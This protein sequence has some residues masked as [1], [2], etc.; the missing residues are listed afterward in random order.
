MSRALVAAILAAWAAAYVIG[1]WRLARRADRPPPT[2][3]AAAAMTA[4]AAVATA[5]LSPLDAL[6]HERFSAHMVQHLLLLMVA[7]P[8]LLVANPFPVLLWALPA[9]ARIALRPLFTRHGLVRRGLR[10]L[11]DARR[12]WG[13]FAATV[14]GWHLPALYDLA[15]GAESVH[16]LE[17]GTLFAAALLFWWPLLDPAPHVRATVRPAVAV[18]YVVLAG[19]Q[20]AALGLGL[21]LWPTVLY[22]SYANAGGS[23]DDQA[24]GGVLMWAVSGVV[25][26]AAVMALVWRFLAAA[27]R[28]RTHGFLDPPRLMREN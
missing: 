25:D 26:M 13:L 11:T 18:V 8:L 15:L 5:L 17:H 3:R 19:F 16:A 23:L 27:D 1:W 4:L 14:W 7:A 28:R 2:W 22:A 9:P 21:M 10:A 24:W 12:A 6:A 20:S